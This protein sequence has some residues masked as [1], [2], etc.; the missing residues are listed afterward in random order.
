MLYGHNVVREPAGPVMSVTSGLSSAGR[1]LL[2]EL[3]AVLQRTGT[4]IPA[5]VAA[6]RDA[7]G[8][9]GPPRDLVDRKFAFLQQPLCQQH[10]LLEQP[11]HRRYP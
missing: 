10:P 7:V 5:K 6:Q 4:Q 1:P 9:P 2:P 11:L 8:E 3:D